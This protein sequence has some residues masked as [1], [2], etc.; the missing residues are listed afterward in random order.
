M[1]A[2]CIICGQKNLDKNTIGIN[3]KLLGEDIS[4]VWIALLSIWDVLSRSSLRKLRSS[5]KK[6]VNCLSE[7]GL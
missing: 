7:V 5:K 1:R 6:D 2:D 3:K 4:T